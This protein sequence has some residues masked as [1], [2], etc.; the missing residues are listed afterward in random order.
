[1]KTT[2]EIAD[3]LLHEARKL[4]AREGVTVRSLVE[5]GLR[6]VIAEKLPARELKLRR[7]SFKGNGLQ[8]G[9]HEGDWQRLRELIYQGQGG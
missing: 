9:V 6:K 2:M 7:A 1:M 5:L 3:P 4:A 8:A